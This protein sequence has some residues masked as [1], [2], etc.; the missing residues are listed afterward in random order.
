ME[1]HGGTSGHHVRSGRKP[2]PTSFSHGH[3]HVVTGYTGGS[4]HLCDP[5]TPSSWAGSSA[6]LLPDLP[7][8][9]F[10]STPSQAP[11][12]RLQRY[13]SHLL[14][15][16]VHPCP[17]LPSFCQPGTQGRRLHRGTGVS[18]CWPAGEYKVSK[19]GPN[20]AHNIFRRPAFVVDISLLRYFT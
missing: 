4:A 5:L 18:M 13:T 17:H 14:G 16:W 9:G 12:S 15:T 19:L 3:G 1:A 6:S 2:K 8:I 7:R 20:H 10:A 11:S